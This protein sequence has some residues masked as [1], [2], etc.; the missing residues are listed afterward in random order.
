M[1]PLELKNSLIDALQELNTKDRYLLE[2]D[3]RKRSI[4]ARLAI[5]LQRDC[6]PFFVDVEYNRLGI[7]AKLLGISEDC[8]NYRDE[9]GEAKV[10]PDV[11]VHR[12]GPGGPNLM[13]L[14]LKKTTNR[15]SPGCDRERVEAFLRPPFSYRCGALVTCES[16]PDREPGALLSEWIT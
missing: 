1:S 4:A 7:S 10:F 8:A 5:Y 15:R 11:I 12:R 13:V 14:E 9:H 2:N 3:L 16:R 6:E